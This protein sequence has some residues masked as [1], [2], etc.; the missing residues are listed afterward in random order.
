MDLLLNPEHS[1]KPAGFLR[2]RSRLTG[3]SGADSQRRQLLVLVDLKIVTFLYKK[4]T[5]SGKKE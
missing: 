5:N 4:V 3:K 1:A 2:S